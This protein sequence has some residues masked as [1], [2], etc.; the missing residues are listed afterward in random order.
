MYLGQINWTFAGLNLERQKMNRLKKKSL[1]VTLTTLLLTSQGIFAQITKTYTLSDVFELAIAN[2]KQ[3]KLSQVGVEMA[4]SATNLTKTALLP[5]LDASL[6]ASYIGNGSITN[7]DFTNVQSI[8]MPHFGNNFSIEVSQVIFAGGAISSSIQKAR[9]E[10]QVA[11]LNYDR[12][13]LDI[14]FLVTGYYLDLYKLKNEREVILK[15]IEQ[16]EILIQEIKS[17]ESQGMALSSDV[18]RYELMLQNLKLSLIEIDNNSNII[19]NQLVITC[20]LS[21]ETLIVPDSS[22]LQLDLRAVN[23]DTF[24]QQAAQNLP[25]LKSAAINKEIAIKELRI[26][27]A[28]YYPHIAVMAA[29]NFDGPILIEVPT[30]NKNFNYWYAGLGIRYNL[31]SLYKSN[32][33]V[34]LANKKQLIAEHTEALTLEHTQVAIHNAYTRFKESFDKLTVY[35]TSSRLANENYRIINNR[36]LNELVLITEMLDASNTKLNAEL[37]VVNA[38]LNIIY[39]YYRLQREI[40]TKVRK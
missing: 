27:K 18:T 23:Q 37:Q 9:L 28:D 2:S 30:I 31:A 10:E 21:A 14:C 11:Q 29:N 38:K 26:A 34:K 19:N 25:E 35:E 20:G 12:N 13:E 6:S 40:G 33:K 15:N 8:E 22:V 1:I 5:S 39:N 7:R 3:L 16:T 36:Y 4:Q 24:L 17:K 32:R